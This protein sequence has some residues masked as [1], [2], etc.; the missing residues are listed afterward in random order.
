MRRYKKNFSCISITFLTL[1]IF[2]SIIRAV[3][4]GDSTVSV[5]INDNYYWIVTKHSAGSPFTTGDKYNLSVQN[6]YGAGGNLNMDIRLDYYNSTGDTW[7]TRINGLFLTFNETLDE[8]QYQ[9][10][11]YFL[12][13]WI[14]VIPT[15][16]NLTL[17]GEYFISS[18]GS[19][20]DS[21][22]I[23]NTTLTLDFSSY[24]LKCIYTYNESGVLTKFSC[25]S[26]I[27]STVILEMMMDYDE[28]NNGVDDGGD[29]DG[30][31]SSD[32]GGDDGTDNGGDNQNGIPFGN[33]YIIITSIGIL[34]SLISLRRKI[35]KN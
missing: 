1:L 11:L 8:I 2:S 35:I 6:I 33:S 5:N 31:G 32:D 23:S 25:E 7:S 22:T 20:I 26:S 30:N 4:I 18:S 34:I 17:I 27:F 14:F 10:G 19:V 24:Y 12:Y 16:L 13:G 28:S 29:D 3:T 9:I 15:P 21:V